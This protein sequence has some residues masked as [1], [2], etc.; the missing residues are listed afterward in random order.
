MN[1]IHDLGCM[2][3]FG[4]IERHEEIFHTEWV[5][6]LLVTAEALGIG[7]RNVPFTYWH[8]SP[9]AVKR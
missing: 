7:P 1:G 4:P 8:C 5:H 9:H 2:H 6:A 3:G